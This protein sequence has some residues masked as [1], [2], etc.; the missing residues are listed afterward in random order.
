MIMIDPVSIN[1]WCSNLSSEIHPFYLYSLMFSK[2][3]SIDNLNSFVCV[4]GG[5]L[6]LNKA[7]GGSGVTNY[8]T[9]SIGKFVA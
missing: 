8:N 5:E 1:Y 6:H 3:E 2:S 7:I 4:G 9:P